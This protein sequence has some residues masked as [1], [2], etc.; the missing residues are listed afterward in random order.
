MLSVII[1]VGPGRLEHLTW[2]LAFLE[3]QTYRDFEVLVVENAGEDLSP[4]VREISRPIKILCQGQQAP[5]L[6][7]VNRNAG[8]AMA[9]SDFL[10]FLDVDVLLHPKALS[11]YA[12]DFRNFPMRAI[13]GPYHW[14]APLEVVG[15]WDALSL[16]ADEG[17][18]KEKGPRVAFDT[19]LPWECVS[20]DSLYCDY[21]KSLMLLAGNMAIHRKVFQCAGGFWEDLSNGIDGAFGVAL[22]QSGHVF[23]FDRRA[24]GYHLYHPAYEWV[25]FTETRQKLIERFHS[26]SSWIGQMKNWGWPWQ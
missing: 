4:A 22:C 2:C 17:I 8:A 16:I 13:A 7:A 23:S 14:T 15:D 5:N 10:L 1:P 26:D 25:D 3:K 12:E 18:E 21:Y 11:Y 9:D 6:G 19:R 24:V 20:P